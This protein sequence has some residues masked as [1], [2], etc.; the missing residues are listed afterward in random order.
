MF[1]EFV[2]FSVPAVLVAASAFAS[3]S[4]LS[5][6]ARTAVPHEVQQL[7]VID[8][9][10]MQ[11]STAAMDLKERVMPPEL[12]QFDEALRKSGLN[13]N[14]DVD[15]LAFALFRPSASSEGLVTVGAGRRLR[16]VCCRPGRSAGP[17]RLAELRSDV[18]PASSDTNTLGNK[19][20]RR[21]TVGIA[22][23]VRWRAGGDNPPS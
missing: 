13:E 9:R 7:V 18:R 3:A 6:D 22:S 21:P 23:A 4:Q 20:V 17:S 8:Y 16:A 1:K 19:P 11:N 2:K 15:Q 10:A 12:K 5:T 14:H